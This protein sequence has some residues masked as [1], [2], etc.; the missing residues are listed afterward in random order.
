MQIPKS[1]NILS[2]IYQIQIEP[3]EFINGNGSV[4]RGNINFHKRLIQIADDTDKSN[5]IKT[6]FHEVAHAICSEL[7]LYEGEQDEAFIERFAVGL[8]D[9][10]IRNKLIKE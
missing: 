6:L 4:C 7:Q 9:T 8:S 5:M 3:E 1:I 10:L 2:S